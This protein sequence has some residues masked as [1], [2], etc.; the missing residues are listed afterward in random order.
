MYFVEV[1]E[2]RWS[3]GA[4]LLVF[5][6]GIRHVMLT[7]ILTA[8]ECQSLYL[9]QFSNLRVERLHLR[10]QK[11]QLLTNIYIQRLC[12]RVRFHVSCQNH[13]LY[14]YECFSHRTC[15][16]HT[17]LFSSLGSLSRLRQCLQDVLNGF[18]TVLFEGCNLWD[19]CGGM[20]SACT[21]EHIYFQLLHISWLTRV[22]ITS[23][24]CLGWQYQPSSEKLFSQR[25]RWC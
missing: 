13:S 11:A 24:T 16:Y 23:P 5:S 20:Q 17:H 21:S 15:Y 6:S 4:V 18:M 7:A 2:C 19:M 1:T 12:I 3:S 9:Q 25:R 8:D 14:L 22:I 10:R